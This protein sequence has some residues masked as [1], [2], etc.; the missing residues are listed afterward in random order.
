[1]V[2]A[3]IF[4]GLY[5][6]HADATVALLFLWGTVLLHL[7]HLAHSTRKGYTSGTLPFTL[8]AAVRMLYLSYKLPLYF[9]PVEPPAWLSALLSSVPMGCQFFAAFHRSQQSCNAHALRDGHRPTIIVDVVRQAL[10]H[11]CGPG[12]LMYWLLVSPRGRLA[13]FVVVSL[14]IGWQVSVFFYCA[15]L[16]WLELLGREQ[17]EA[18]GAVATR[19]VCFG[20]QGAWCAIG[21]LSPKGFKDHFIISQGSFL[22]AEWIGTVLYVRAPA[23]RLAAAETTSDTRL[24]ERHTATL[25]ISAGRLLRRQQPMLE[26]VRRNVDR[27][28][29][30]DRVVPR[31]P[32]HAG[33]M[34]AR[35][36]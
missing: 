35:A 30:A 8:L 32:P 5:A 25:S 16:A 26:E 19:A 20:V 9:G 6:E 28:E 34:A 31:L 27:S 13:G 15:W 22:A 14:G 7:I 2:S 1:M 17:S 23:V 4:V 29:H 18:R 3:N 11:T 24:H 21:W 12:L 33:S 10:V 36:A